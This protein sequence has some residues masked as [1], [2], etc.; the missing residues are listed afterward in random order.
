MRQR[1]AALAL[2]LCLT[3]TAC[4]GQGGGQACRASADDDQLMFPHDH[5]SFV[6]PV[7]M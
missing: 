5:A 6:S 2:L 3:L 4:G 1:G 7:R